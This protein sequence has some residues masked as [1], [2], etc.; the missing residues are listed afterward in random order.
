M[1]IDKNDPSEASTRLLGA[2]TLNIALNKEPSTSPLHKQGKIRS[3]SKK[4]IEKFKQTNHQ[5]EKEH[6]SP[7]SEDCFQ[8]PGP[9]D[10][11]HDTDS[12]QLG[13]RMKK[14]HADE[15]E[16]YLRPDIFCEFFIMH[17]LFYFCLGPFII[18]LT[19]IL[20]PHVLRN[21][22]FMGWRSGVIRQ[23][24]EFFATA[25]FLTI[26]Y[27][28][29]TAGLEAI[30]VYMM[31]V[32]V[33]IRLICISSKYAY[34]SDCFI[35]ILKT[36]T[37]TEK[38]LSNQLPFIPEWRVQGDYLIKQ[39]L[40]SA[41]LR[42]EIETSTFS[43]SFLGTSLTKSGVLRSPTKGE[44]KSVWQ[45]EAPKEEDEYSVSK[46]IEPNTQ[47]KVDGYALAFDFIQHA[48]KVRYRHLKSFSMVISVL[49]A[50]LPTFYR[51]FEIYYQKQDIPLFTGKPYAAVILFL[52]NAIFFWMNLVIIVTVIED[53]KTK[54]FCLKQVG[55][56]ITSKNV[57]SSS[58]RK[59]CPTVNIFDAA[60]LK[61]WLDLR[62]LIN[63]YGKKYIHRNHFNVAA[64][65]TFYAFILAILLLQLLGVINVYNDPLSLIVFGYESAVFFVIFIV[66]MYGGACVN[67]QYKTHKAELKRVKGFISKFQKLSYLY[68]GE[69][70]I[71]PENPVYREGFRALK[72][73]LG[74]ENLQ[75]KLVERSQKLMSTLDE[76]VEDLTFEEANSPFTVMGTAVNFTVVKSLLITVASILFAISQRFFG[77]LWF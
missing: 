3:I 46:E 2:S 57:C 45:E 41:L 10:I 9:E 68:V 27:S 13:C 48:K 29:K 60:N 40:N 11:V 71:E 24:L 53:I 49:R 77:K 17:L 37:L 44:K 58:D 12:D 6:N 70:A 52:I 32:A 5:L 36:R 69:N 72:Q 14:H 26:F 42:L 51:I 4:F 7:F 25:L 54:I 63:D 15:H 22:A 20:G 73:E 28:T 43:F 18:L 64:S 30:E 16:I 56:M 39:E 74:E 21:Q 33:L 76:L 34:Q 8:S 62:K 47:F 38:Q 19:P 59:L 61:A 66:S 65:L 1:E 67:D 23:Y 50:L 55:Y 35:R 31:V 75:T